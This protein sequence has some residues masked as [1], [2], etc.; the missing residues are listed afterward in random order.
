MRISWP[1]GVVVGLA[2][3]HVAGEVKLQF[4]GALGLAVL[5]AGD[6]LLGVAALGPDDEAVGLDVEQADA[7]HVGDGDE[8]AAGDDDGLFAV[9]Q[10][11][12]LD[13]EALGAAGRHAELA[14][15]P[16]GRRRGRR[17]PRGR[18]RRRRQGQ[19]PG[20]DGKG[21]GPARARPRRRRRQAPAGGWSGGGPP[22]GSS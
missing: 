1:C 22:C 6:E 17:R 8:D 4:A 10:R 14:R 2:D 3:L 15:R 21:P 20:A 19:R 11:F 9:G 16:A 18:L 12:A 5:Q 13:V 7:G